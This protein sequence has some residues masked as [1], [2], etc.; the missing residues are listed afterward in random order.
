MA[1]RLN[2]FLGDSP[3]RTLLKLLVIS[4]IVGVVM[5]AINWY[6]VDIYFWLR[7]MVVHLWETGFAALGRFGSYLVLGAT[8]VIPIFLLLRL[9]NYRR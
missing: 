6:P 1:E 2:R 9:V 7:D 4:F 3:L 8:I 5:S